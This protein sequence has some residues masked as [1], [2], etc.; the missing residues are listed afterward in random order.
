MRNIR[1]TITL[2]DYIIDFCR[3]NRVTTNRLLFDADISPG[4]MKSFK[5]NRISIR[6]YF[7]L[8]DAMCLHSAFPVEFYLYKLKNIVQTD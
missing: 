8:C 4:C 7:L 5:E 1:R 3:H 2:K 6:Q